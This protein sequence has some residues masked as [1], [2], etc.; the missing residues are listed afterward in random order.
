MPNKGR[1]GKLL[2]LFLRKNRLNILVAIL[3]VSIL[4]TS[5]FFS[6][7]T[8][9]LNTREVTGALIFNPNDRINL[10]E[11]IS[12]DG[13]IYK[14][15]M[16]S[17]HIIAESGTFLI[18]SENHYLWKIISEKINDPIVLKD[19]QSISKITTN[20]NVIVHIN[21]VS[22]PLN[23]NGTYY[24]IGV[25]TNLTNPVIFIAEKY[26]QTFFNNITLSGLYIS[27]ANL[28]KYFNLNL[29]L[30][31]QQLL[32][33]F[34]N[35]TLGNNTK[36]V[37]LATRISYLQSISLSGQEIAQIK[38]SNVLN[39]FNNFMGGIFNFSGYTYL[40][41]VLNHTDEQLL[42]IS[43]ANNS[44]SSMEY[45]FIFAPLCINTSQMEG[46]VTFNY[47]PSYIYYLI[48]ATG[49]KFN[50]IFTNVSL[51]FG[52]IDP[53]TIYSTG[54][55]PA[56]VD[57]LWNMNDTG[58][59][60]QGFALGFNFHE[61]L[62]LI[63]DL[64]PIPSSIINAVLNY[65]KNF[66]V[67]LYLLINDNLMFSLNSTFLH[68]IAILI[69]PNT[70]FNINILSP[71]E[72]QGVLY[73][74]NKFLGINSTIP[75]L[76][77]SNIYSNVVFNKTQETVSGIL[78]SVPSITSSFSEPFKN[79]SVIVM[80]SLH[81]NMSIMFVH[82][83]LKDYFVNGTITLVRD[84]F[85]WWNVIS[86]I[87]SP[88]LVFNPIIYMSNKS[89]YDFK[90]VQV[91]LNSSSIALYNQ[92]FG[93][94]EDLNGFIW[95]TQGIYP[96]IHT[97]ITL[98]GVFMSQININIEHILE[99]LNISLSEGLSN[100]INAFNFTITINT[101]NLFLVNNVI[102]NNHQILPLDILASITPSNIINPIISTL[103]GFLNENLTSTLVQNIGQQ[104]INS[105]R[106]IINNFN[107]KFLLA[108]SPNYSIFNQTYYLLFSPLNVPTDNGL[109][110]SEI[111]L[112]NL[113]YKFSFGNIT[114]SFVIGTVVPSGYRTT[115]YEFLDVQDLWDTSYRSV[116]VYGFALGLT[117]NNIINW[118]LPL[119][120]IP[121]SVINTVLNY[122]NDFNVGVFLLFDQNLSIKLSSD[123]YKCVAILIV[124]DFVGNPN[125]LEPMEIKGILFQ[126]S[127]L[128]KLPPDFNFPVIIANSVLTNPLFPNQE[129]TVSGILL[130]D[131]QLMSTLPEPFTNMAILITNPWSSSPNIM[132]VH[133]IKNYI[134]INGTITLVRDNTG[135]WNISSIIPSPFIN[136]N[137]NIYNENPSYFTYKNVMVTMNTTS[138]ALFG[139]T[140][141]IN[142]AFTAPYIWIS[143]GSYP[144]LD[145][146]VN[147]SGVF[148]SS[149]NLNLTYIFSIFHINLPLVVQNLISMFNITIS[150]LGDA[151]LI[152]NEVSGINKM[153]ASMEILETFT[154]SNLYN[155]VSEYAGSYLN[156]LL[157]YS[158]IN[159]IYN[160]INNTNEQVLLGYD[161]QN[162]I[163]N[164]RFYILFAPTSINSEELE[165]VSNVTF[166]ESNLCLYINLSIH[167]SVIIGSIIDNSV[168]SS[169]YVQATVPELWGMKSKGVSVNAWA[170]G[171]DAFD[172]SSFLNNE[173]QQYFK[174][175]VSDL[176]QMSQ[177]LNPAIFVLI[178]PDIFLNSSTSIWHSFALAVVPNYPW[179]ST[180]LG[181]FTF[182]GVVYNAGQFFRTGWDL[183]ILFVGWMGT[184]MPVYPY[185][186]LEQIAESKNQSLATPI[187]TT[188]LITGTSLK[189]I[190]N[191]LS[192]WI[193]G[194][195]IVNYLP[196]DIGIYD[197][198]WSSQNMTYNV[199]VIYPVLGTGSSYLTK[200]VDV[201]GYYVNY[202]E[203]ILWLET[204][205]GIYNE[206][207]YNVGEY[208][209]YLV[210]SIISSAGLVTD[211]LN[212]FIIAVD[213]VDN[214]TSGN[215]I[216]SGYTGTIYI[217]RTVY[218]SGDIA[219]PIN[220]YLMDNSGLSLNY[221][222]PVVYYDIITP[223]G[224]EYSGTLNYNLILIPFFADNMSN[225][226]VLPAELGTYQV[227]L[228][229]YA[230]YGFGQLL[231]SDIYYFNVV[232]TK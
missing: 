31:E 224:E 14:I 15:N 56:S 28:S 187:T 220:C 194:L 198:C 37:I 183:P 47:Y 129:M 137:I 62:N 184:S 33:S 128:F 78:L 25:S 158:V 226:L 107:V 95:F 75:I 192:T 55:V 67:G 146:H 91:T 130:A 57:E 165:G 113:H 85:G 92:T 193:N 202:T 155:L 232:M 101:N 96:M 49:L 140:F 141:G 169:G 76:I 188:G 215:V 44:I 109:L 69:V 201:S 151:I 205:I 178:D 115:G 225:I 13:N 81:D 168:N 12:N 7:T 4:I 114:I 63:D 29:S 134:A 159:E 3:L 154:P 120:K 102:F 133:S 77:S 170:V 73:H 173:F 19:S 148:L 16:T 218:N 174:I 229:A 68:G 161:I 171:I 121:G 112:S 30:M 32:Q 119:F 221:Q 23:I 189:T 64:Y 206:S 9:I 231:A 11:I 72:V 40:T 48:N 131:S 34:I 21:A 213:I 210:N 208:L 84:R 126:S 105:L 20:Q 195:N 167:F 103:S 59:S 108:I 53:Y 100:L 22:L 125:I 117:L 50:I 150:G 46:M 212:G 122:T 26:I 156:N 177:V 197:L 116:N 27:A 74:A 135:W 227:T 118:T 79:I 43:N 211:I 98:Q 52:V 58:V 70:T 185:M 60:V 93:I 157:S 90:N 200:H 219:V 216:L 172:V 82:N 6:S 97:E 222:V 5:T 86:V 207:S 123:W 1:E 10:G 42:I 89:F 124:P 176:V 147:I 36:N 144:L 175:D 217:N 39:F 160:F 214:S 182:N 83:Y 41:W 143:E 136:F 66:N 132:L 181:Y 209:S 191:I 138:L 54:F 45:D 196:V 199:P 8:N 71:I 223:N 149:L 104:V 166:A 61:A 106:S 2:P 38:P 17:D 110:I 153:T 152:A 35:I 111:G 24:T 162:N 164:L 204:L 51:K 88:I 139:Y 179:Q 145:T 65:T 186:S 80:N 228:T 87:P 18:Q 203:A 99:V 230:Y 142:Q 163:N 127:S 180:T 94:N 190:G